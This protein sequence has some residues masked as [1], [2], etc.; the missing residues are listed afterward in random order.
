M[1]VKSD[2]SFVVLNP[3]HLCPTSTKVYNLSVVTQ[4]GAPKKSIKRTVFCTKLPR[5]SL[6]SSQ[7]NTN[8]FKMKLFITIIF[9]IFTI[10]VAQEGSGLS[11]PEY[12]YE[13]EAYEPAPRRRFQ[14]ANDVGL[15]NDVEEEE[16]QSTEI[17]EDYQQTSNQ[18]PQESNQYQQISNQSAQDSNQ[19]EIETNQSEQITNQYPQ[20]TNQTAQV[21]NQYPQVTNQSPQVTNQY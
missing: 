19:S 14:M 12:E 18:F 3:L 8:F 7:T 11:N 15:S 1:Q 4:G 20:V 21:S 9:S 17:I 10:A 13:P 5:F 16:E 6:L 2:L